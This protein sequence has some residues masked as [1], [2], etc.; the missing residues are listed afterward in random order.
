M[1]LDIIYNKY[2]IVSI[3]GVAKNSGKTVALNHLVGEATNKGIMLGIISAGRDG[4]STDI[5]TETE[6]PKIFVEQGTIVGTTAHLLSLSDVVV[7]IMEVTD[8]RTPLG[9]ILIGRVRDSGYIQIAGPQTARE[10]R[11]ISN[12]LLNLGAEIIII[13]GAMDRKASASPS[14]SEATI[15]STGAV[16]SRDIDKVIEKTVHLANLFG[17]PSVEGLKNREIVEKALNKGKVSIIDE[18]LNIDILRIKSALNNGKVIADNIENR[19]KYV[20]IPGSLVKS[21]LEDIIMSTDKYKDV[22]IVVIDGTKV[23]ISPKDWLKFKRYGVDVK[24]LN[25][26]N[27]VAITLNSYAPQGYYFDPKELLNKM[28]YHIKSIPVMDLLLGGEEFGVYG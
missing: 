27:L 25:P 4:E 6:K 2:K 10:V 9:K 7:E 3:V 11:E 17:L 19:S 14:I 20:V 8:Y 24:V 23:F 12:L 21:T 28:R 16:L 18:D 22:S 26:I 1:L 13:D 5:V 15:L